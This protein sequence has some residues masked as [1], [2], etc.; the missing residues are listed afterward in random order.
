MSRLIFEDKSYV[1]IYKKPDGKI[2]ISIGAKDVSSP[3]SFTV[4]SV[5]ITQEELN[6]LISLKD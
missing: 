4:N 1:E 3:T 5:E 2:L 6:K